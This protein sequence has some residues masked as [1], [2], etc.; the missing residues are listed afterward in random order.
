MSRKLLLFAVVALVAAAGCIRLGFWQLERLHT[1]R[2]RNALVARRLAD[3]PVPVGALP[4]DTGELRYRR[5]TARGRYDFAR[6]IILTSRSRNGAPGVNLV[7]PLRVDGS[8]T[9][10]LVNRGWVYSPDGATVTA[11]DW[12]EPD[13]ATVSGYVE[14]MSA[15]RG[16]G[17]IANRPT[18]LRWLERAEVER[19]LGAPVAPFV[20]VQTEGGA[21]PAD[22]IPVRLAL[23]RMDEGAHLSYAV[24]WFSFAAIALIGLGVWVVKERREGRATG[25]G[26]AT[27]EG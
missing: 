10:V 21:P 4:R 26:G 9:L 24:Q 5:A 20:V 18:A 3:A 27:G 15:G 12:R 25:D 1:R 2:A 6:E 11:E 19:R 7:T 22:S 8:D 16:S 23:P 13:T 17:A 14:P